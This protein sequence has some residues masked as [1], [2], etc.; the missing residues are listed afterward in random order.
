AIVTDDGAVTGVLIAWSGVLSGS[1]N[2]SPAWS[3]TL[4]VPPG[5]PAGSLEFI[6]QAVDA[7]G[8]LSAPFVLQVPVN[9]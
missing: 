9:N 6:I 2:T 1:S 3:F 4:L 7:A 5:T 8:N